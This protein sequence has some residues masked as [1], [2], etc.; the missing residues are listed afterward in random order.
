MGHDW[1]KV[2]LLSFISALTNSAIRIDTSTRTEETR[3]QMQK[4][5]HL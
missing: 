5:S 4:I 2:T 1:K 3:R